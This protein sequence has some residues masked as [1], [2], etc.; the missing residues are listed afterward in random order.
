MATRTSVVDLRTMADATE[1]VG[2]T[3]TTR[4]YEAAVVTAT[5]AALRRSANE[6]S[7]VII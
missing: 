7:N 1:A 6:K 5:A 2:S 4:T 3:K